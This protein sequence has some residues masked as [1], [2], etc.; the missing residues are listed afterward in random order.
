MV[1]GWLAR[2]VDGFRLD[3]FNAFLKDPS[4]ARTR[5][6]R[7]HVGRGTGR[8][9]CTTA[10]SRTSRSSSTASGRSSTRQPGRMSVGELFDGTVE[11]AAELRDRPPPRLRLGAARDA[12]GGRRAPRRRSRSARRR[13]A[14]RAGRRPS[15][16]NHDQPRQASRGWRPPSVPTAE[17]RDRPGRR[18]PAPDPA[19]DAVPVLRRGDRACATSTCPA[20]ESVDPPAAWVGPEFEWWDRSRSRTP[21]PWTAVPAP[22][23]RRGRPWLRLG[24]DAATRNVARAARRSGLG[25]GPVPAA[26]R[27][28]GRDAG[29]PGRRPEPR[30][31]T[32][33]TTSSRTGG[34]QRDS[35]V[36]VVLNVGRTATAWRLPDVPGRTGWQPRL[37]TGAGSGADAPLAP[38]DDDRHRAGR[39]D[40]SSRR[41]AD[42]QRG[43]PCYHDGRSTPAT[44]GSTTCRSIS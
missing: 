23:S 44:P 12:L 1:R 40:G 43:R 32:V 14:P 21:M 19:R 3:V 35:I 17:R 27:A 10:T 9:T 38:G 37:R 6:G 33:T 31:R 18:R 24:P 5:P 11:T 34:R 29:A 4:C 15:L 39:G 28:A 20:R 2:G 36:L 26:D 7:G 30:A 22:G 41:S 42:R 16:S 8:S 13:S 25:P